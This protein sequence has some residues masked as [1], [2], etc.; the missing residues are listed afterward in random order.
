VVNGKA[1][2]YEHASKRHMLQKRLDYV[3]NIY[4]DIIP[5]STT[6]TNHKAYVIA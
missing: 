4:V 2:V 6:N 5:S 1:C 3:L